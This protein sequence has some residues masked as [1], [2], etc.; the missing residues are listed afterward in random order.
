MW[1]AVSQNDCKLIEYISDQKGEAKRTVV[2]TLKLVLY[3]LMCILYQL[4]HLVLLFFLK[5][6]F[7]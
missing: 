1:S 4:T 3:Y 7:L 2:A 6:F 5:T